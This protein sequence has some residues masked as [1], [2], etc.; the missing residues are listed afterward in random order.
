MALRLDQENDDMRLSTLIR[1]GGAAAILAGLLRAASSF[2]AGGSEVERQALYFIV[3]LLLLLGAFA[4]YAQNHDAVGSWGAAG[5]LT[6]VAGILLVRSSRAVPGLDLYPAGALS[7][8][9]G[10]VLL[11][12]A[13]WRTAKGSAVVPVLLL[14]SIV[15]G[16]VGEMVS[17]ASLF[18]AAGVLFGAAVV[19][20]GM[21]VFRGCSQRS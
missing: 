12:F 14:L 4:A 10:W 21:Q 15:I 7:V 11:T 5:F 2:T 1:V 17:R 16:L 20:A 18:V 19:G 9:V 6:I 3:D 8:G 13:W